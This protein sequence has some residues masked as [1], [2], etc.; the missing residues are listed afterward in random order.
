M[1]RGNKKGNNTQQ[2]SHLCGGLDVVKIYPFKYCLH[3][4]A[5]S[6]K[7][8]QEYRNYHIIKSWIKNVLIV[9]YE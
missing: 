5:V 9:Y 3:K 7:L 2:Y 8:F 6:T 4:A 1:I